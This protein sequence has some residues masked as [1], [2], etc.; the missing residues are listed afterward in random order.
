[1]IKKVKV[2]DLRVGV[3]VHDFNCDWEGDNLYI[4]KNF[5]KTPDTIDILN[6]WGIKEVYIDTERGL[7]V[8]ENKTARDKEVP[9][10]ETLPSSASLHSP[11]EIHVPLHKEL[12]AAKKIADDAV[13]L[14][15]MNNKRVLKGDVPDVKGTYELADRMKDSITRNRDALFLLTQIRDKD[16]YTL[17][18]S[19]SVSSLVLNMCHFYEL[20]EYKTL[21]LAVGAL[22]HDIGKT[23][24]PANILNKPGRLTEKEYRLIKRH[25]NYS[26]TLLKSAKGL[27]LECYDIALHHHERYD[28]KGYPDGLKREQ[29]NFGSQLTC[30]CDVFDA[31]TSERC[32][33]SGVDSVTGLKRIFEDAG[34]VFS[35]KLAHDFIK[36]LGVYPIGTCVTLD[37]GRSGV[38]VNSN[39][40]I[41][42]P[43]VH[44]FYDENEKKKIEPEK[45]DLS[46][47][48]GNVA[49][50]A[51]PEKFGVSSQ[52]LLKKMAPS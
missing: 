45:V 47:T 42:K 44:V 33:K 16:E 20:P 10:H 48:G 5:I 38:V 6:N 18:H 24:V 3:F 22:F 36:C 25:A 40:D 34:K 52:V 11:R 23:M 26:V 9:F 8:L 1:M 32:Y 29:I 43:I 28:G 49:S 41:M 19:I 17:Y 51:D 39:E 35:K 4:E 14:L 12:K 31:C 50:Y 37:D 21:D 30:V 13:S 15:D 7:D 27:P 2:N 46:Q